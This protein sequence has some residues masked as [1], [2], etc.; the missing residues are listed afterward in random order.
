MGA[1]VKPEVDTRDPDEARS[2]LSDVYCPH[3]LDLVGGARGFVCRQSSRGFAKVRLFDLVYGGA[4]VR[5]DPVPFDD[6]VLV[7]R[8]LKGRF[9]VRSTAEGLVG[10]GSGALVMD[11]YGSYQLRWYDS[12]EVLNTV[13]DRDGLERIAAELR[14]WDEPRP[15]RFALGAAASAAAARRWDT[16]TRLLLEETR[17]DDGMAG[18]PLLAAQLFRLAATALLE[19]YPNTVG[20]PE[21]EPAGRVSPAAVR[22]AEAFIELN[23]AEDIGLLE[24]AAAARLSVRGLQAAFSRAGRPSPV[25]YLRETRLR[26]AHAE[27]RERSPEETTVASVAARWGFGNAGR[28]SAEHRR[29]YGCGPSETLRGEGL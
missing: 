23:A 16:A 29:L 19:A 28:F 1:V 3:R 26:R 8:P 4:E 12:A 20:E 17:S 14:G 6:F 18:S 22:R 2:R 9:A 13:L 5:V 24:I 25:A 15:V 10:A 11:A 7:T 21:T 27:L